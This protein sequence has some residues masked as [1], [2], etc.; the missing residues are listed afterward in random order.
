MRVCTVALL[1]KLI[2][3][4]YLTFHRITFVAP[5]GLPGRAPLFTYNRLNYNEKELLWHGVAGKSQVTDHLSDI[6]VA[7]GELPGGVPLFTH[8]RLLCTVN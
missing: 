4:P 1:E 8:D 5:G 3:V 6:F 7:P 2:S